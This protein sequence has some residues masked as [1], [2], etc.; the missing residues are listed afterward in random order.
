LVVPER[1]AEQLYDLERD[2]LEK[3]DLLETGSAA[4]TAKADSLRKAAA[5]IRARQSRKVIADPRLVQLAFDFYPA[6]KVFLLDP[7]DALHHE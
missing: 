6:Y 4:A 5:E 1:K 7:I 3:T 2:P